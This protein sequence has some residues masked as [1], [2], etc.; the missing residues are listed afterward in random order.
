MLIHHSVSIAALSRI[1]TKGVSGT[2]AVAG[3]EVTNP[4]LPNVIVFTLSRI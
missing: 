2:E 3:L 1:L 4:I